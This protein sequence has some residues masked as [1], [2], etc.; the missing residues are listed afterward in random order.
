[1]IL[2]ILVSFTVGL[3]GGMFELKGEDIISPSFGPS[4]GIFCDFYMTPNLSYDLSF[5]MAKAPASTRTTAIVYDSTGQQVFS[6]V[7]GEDFQYFKG[8]LSVNWF[9]FTTIISPSLSAKLGLEQWKFVSGGEVVQSLNGNDFEGIS[10]FLGGG[11]GLR[12]ELVGFVLSAEV[13]S[14]FIFTENKD[15]SGG[16]GGYDD[17]EWDIEVI[18]K[19]GKEF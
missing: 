4:Y 13:F 8:S 10:L 19:L 6:E 12:C 9:P 17:N 2:Y 1:M 14:D 15:W 16:F 5:Q 11:G 3:Q 7:R 18:F